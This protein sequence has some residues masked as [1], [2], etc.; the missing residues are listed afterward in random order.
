MVNTPNEADFVKY[1]SFVKERALEGQAVVL[2]DYASEAHRNQHDILHYKII[3]AHYDSKSVDEPANPKDHMKH[4]S[5]RLVEL[6]LLKKRPEAM[7]CPSLTKPMFALHKQDKDKQRHEAHEA[8]EEDCSCRV[9]LLLCVIK[10]Q[11]WI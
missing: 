10:V 2:V 3:S 4:E 8:S 1:L 11:L 5:R 6:Q 9:E 7:S